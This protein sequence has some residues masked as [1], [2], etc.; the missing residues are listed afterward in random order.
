MTTRKC[1]ACGKPAGRRPENPY[2]PFCSERCRLLDLGRWF[3][4]SYRVPVRRDEWDEAP[5]IPRPDD[6]EED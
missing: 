2:D 6:R 4:E 5:A 1:P 3:D